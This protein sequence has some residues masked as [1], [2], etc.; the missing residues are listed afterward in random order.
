MFPPRD[1]PEQKNPI[2]RPCDH[3]SLH[4]NSDECTS[5]TTNPRRLICSKSRT[6][7]LTPSYFPPK[8]LKQSDSLPPVSVSKHYVFGFR[9]KELYSGSPIH[10]LPPIRSECNH[11]VIYSAAS[12]GVIHDLTLNAQSYFEGHTDDITCLSLDRSGMYVVSGQLG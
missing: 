1:H 6:S 4:S 2:E 7:Y 10:C 11:V 5:T 3:M 9:S 8:L 12:L